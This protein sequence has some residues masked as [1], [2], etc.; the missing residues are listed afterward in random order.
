MKLNSFFQNW[1]VL[2]TSPREYWVLIQNKTSRILLFFVI[3][4]LILSISQIFWFQLKTLPVIRSGIATVATEVITHF[5]SALELEWN[6]ERLDSNQTR[7]VTIYYPSVIQAEALQLPQF[8][9]YYVPGIE[10][11]DQVSAELKERSLFIITPSTI[12]MRDQGQNWS[13]FPL[14]TLLGSESVVVNQS[15]LPQVL[16]SIT[17]QVNELVSL[18][19]IFSWI[20]IP[21]LFILGRL[22]EALFQ[23]LLLYFLIKLFRPQ[24]SWVQAWRLSLLITLVATLIEEIT[25]WVYPGLTLPM[26]ALAFWCVAATVFWTV[27]PR[28]L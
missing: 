25:L 24:F 15:S 5:P 27:R 19:S 20:L 10:D 1:Y 9:G 26:F 22:W 4:C 17:G 23:T 13:P 14:D 2:L 7:P 16:D 6:G 11:L 28:T 18:L 12:W 21:P 8:L 3:S